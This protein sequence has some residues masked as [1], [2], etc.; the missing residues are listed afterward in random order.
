MK[1][2]RCCIFVTHK[3]SRPLTHA[4]TAAEEGG[5]RGRERKP[6]PYQPCA[7]CMYGYCGVLSDICC[8]LSEKSSSLILLYNENKRLLYC[9]LSEHKEG[10]KSRQGRRAG[11]QKMLWPAD[12]GSS[13]TGETDPGLKSNAALSSRRTRIESVFKSALIQRSLTTLTCTVSAMMRVK[14][15]LKNIEDTIYS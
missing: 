10:D 1:P 3:S 4:T 12:W 8:L 5:R 9:I 13:V 7:W 11:P 2:C 6:S 14:T 15:W